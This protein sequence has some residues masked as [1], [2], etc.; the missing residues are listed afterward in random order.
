LNALVR[1]KLI[2]AKAMPLLDGD[3]RER[4]AVHSLP[5]IAR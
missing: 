4:R 2:Y 5:H 1:F 3:M